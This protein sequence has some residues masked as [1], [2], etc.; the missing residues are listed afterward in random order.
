MSVSYRMQRNKQYVLV[1]SDL[2]NLIKLMY[3]CCFLYIQYRVMKYEISHKNRSNIDC[4][5]KQ[6]CGSALVLMR[7]RIRILNTD[8]DPGQPNECGSRSIRIHNTGK[9]I[10]KMCYFKQVYMCVTDG[11]VRRFNDRCLF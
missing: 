10:L 11:V 7:I 5:R 6:C 3:A 2:I 8:L 1:H 4:R 9:N